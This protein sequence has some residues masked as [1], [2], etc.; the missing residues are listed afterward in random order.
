MFRF[1]SL[2]VV[3]VVALL[4]AS[5][6]FSQNVGKV[7][8][9]ISDM[10]DQIAAGQSVKVTVTITNTGKTTWTSENVYAHELSVFDIRKE[11][12]GEWKLEPGQS[13][14]LQYTVTAPE[15]S[16]SFKMRIVIYDG[17]K[18][19]GHRSKKVEVVSL[20]GK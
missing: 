11:W 2:I 6:I 17:N 18:K 14:E 4:A 16:G 15:K 8:A 5:S 10:P 3:F 20:T 7:K 13:K 1:S 19:I 12:S 9:T